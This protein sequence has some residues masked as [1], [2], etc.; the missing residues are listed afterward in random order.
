MIILLLAVAI[1]GASRINRQRLQSKVESTAPSISDVL[2]ATPIS[3]VESAA[4]TATVLPETA[5]AGQGALVLPVSTAADNVNVQL[6]IVAV[7]RTFM[8]VTVDG[9]VK[10]DG[11]VVP[12]NAYPFE[13]ENQIDVLTGN[14]AA[15]RI[16]YNQRDLGLMGDFG[17]VVNLV[18]LAEGIATPTSAPTATGTATLR[19]TPTPN[20]TQTPTPTSTPTP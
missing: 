20:P 11:R 5:Q 8:R 14:A 3:S 17:Q 1:W 18:Y 6:N 4:G 13:A 15:L 10:F 19:V 2:L 7:E 16:V 9:K 12:G